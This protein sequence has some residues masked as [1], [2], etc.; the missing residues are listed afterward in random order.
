MT[1]ITTIPAATFTIEHLALIYRACIS[2]HSFLHRAGAS[3]AL[4][5][6][7]SD[8]LADGAAALFGE[9]ERFYSTAMKAFQARLKPAE[10][11]FTRADIETAREA[12]DFRHHSQAIDGITTQALASLLAKLT[13]MVCDEA[14]VHDEY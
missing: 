11:A 7:K 10:V 14:L 2:R 12:V 3:V 13:G 9:A 6:P 8:R 5:G 4:Q 1:H